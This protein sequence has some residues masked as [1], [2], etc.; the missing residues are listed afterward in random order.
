MLMSNAETTEADTPHVPWKKLHLTQFV[1]PTFDMPLKLDG[2]GEVDNELFEQLVTL[3]RLNQYDA[4][5]KL[6]VGRTIESIPYIRG[7][8][9]ILVGYEPGEDE[10]ECHPDTYKS[11]P[12]EWKAQFVVVSGEELLTPKVK[13]HPCLQEAMG[14]IEE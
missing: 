13:V 12:D 10:F 9:S 6:L 11:L 1:I 4:I 2:S 5:D 7:R 14:I 8:Q 3:E